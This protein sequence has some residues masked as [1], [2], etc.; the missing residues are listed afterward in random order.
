M[1][2]I[3]KLIEQALKGVEVKANYIVKLNYNDVRVE[4]ID[5]EL[6]KLLEENK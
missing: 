5:N 6:I 2:D 4:E 1:T 3:E